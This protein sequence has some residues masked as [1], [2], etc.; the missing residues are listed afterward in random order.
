MV[1]RERK[2]TTLVF[3]LKRFSIVGKGEGKEGRVGF[4]IILCNTCVY[5]MRAM[6]EPEVELVKDRSTFL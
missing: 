2:I 5:T 6:G 1:Q 3:A 4:V